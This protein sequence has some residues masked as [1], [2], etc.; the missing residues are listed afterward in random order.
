MEAAFES[1][2]AA[3]S[4]LAEHSDVGASS[5]QGS[6]ALMELKQRNRELYEGLEAARTRT[7]AAKAALE[8][9]LLQLE[10]LEYEKAHYL[11]EI[12]TCREV[13]S[14]RSPDSHRRLLTCPAVRVLS[15]SSPPSSATSRLAWCKRRSSCGEHPRS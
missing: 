7:A 11:K 2:R 1:L 14:P 9:T 6:L 4:T 12:R 15:H 10:N 8:T 5:T 3:A 13:R